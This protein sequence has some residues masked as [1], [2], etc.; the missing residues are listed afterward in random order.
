MKRILT[1]I[2]FLIGGIMIGVMFQDK[3][4]ALPYIS[5]IFGKKEVEI[6][7]NEAEGE[8]PSAS[9][10]SASKSIKNTKK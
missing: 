8:N 9:V 7:T 2:L 3:I 6:P 1:T 5:K 10:V 4:K